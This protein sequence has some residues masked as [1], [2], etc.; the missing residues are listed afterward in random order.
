[1]SGIRRIGDRFEVVDA[2]GEGAFAYVYRAREVATGRQ[3]AVKVLKE[4]LRSDSEILERFRREVFAVA[5]INSPHVVALHDFGISGD[6]VFIAMEYV[7]GPTLRQLLDEGRWSADVTNHVVGQ[8]A[9]ALAAAHRENIVHRDLKPE[10]VVMVKG[11]HG[12]QV[13]VLDFGLAK[14]AELESKLGLAPLSKAGT[15]FGTPQYMSPEQ[16][17]GRSAERTTDLWALAVM[18]YEMLGGRLPWDGTTPRDI[19]MGVLGQRLEP[20][21]AVHASVT[22]V[23]ELNQF[24][25][26]ALSKNPKERPADATAL[27]RGF[28]QALFGRSRRLTDAKFAGIVSTEFAIPALSV[29]SAVTSAPLPGSPPDALDDATYVERSPSPPSSKRRRLHSSLFDMPAVDGLTAGEEPPASVRSSQPLSGTVMTRSQRMKMDASVSEGIEGALYP[30]SK[31]HRD[32][33]TD[34][35]PRPWR[36]TNLALLIV[37]MIA[38]AT[39]AALVGFIVGRLPH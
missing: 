20:L 15:C 25:A 5:S 9:Q 34:E 27:F 31:D 8:I 22:R 4:A 24:F 35:V 28:E 29:S 30:R 33:L 19:F 23:E 37:G 32:S 10:N 13:K 6:E 39:I 11:A 21:R 38:L 26:R 16:I 36:H 1:M 3:V 14:L 7:Q 17:Q 18:A 12:H 2:I